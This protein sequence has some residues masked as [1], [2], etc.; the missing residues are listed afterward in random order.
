MSTH[1]RSEASRK[2]RLTAASWKSSLAAVRTMRVETNSVLGLTRILKLN[3]PRQ[4]KGKLNSSKTN[5][6]ESL[7][8][9]ATPK[10]PP[11]Q[12]IEAARLLE[13]AKRKEP[14]DK[15]GFVKI[16]NAALEIHGFCLRIDATGEVCRKLYL[17][18]NGVIKLQRTGGG[19]RSFATQSLHSFHTFAPTTKRNQLPNATESGI[20]QLLFFLTLGRYLP[21][22]WRLNILT[23]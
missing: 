14:P 9:L 19:K 4:M 8:F 10:R 18:P 7:K 3:H 16:I 1:E 6:F 2:R 20:Q 21:R 17:D 15:K 5:D 23:G 12:I 11:E 22:L 13:L